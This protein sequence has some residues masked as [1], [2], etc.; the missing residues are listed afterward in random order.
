MPIKQIQFGEGDLAKIF[1]SPDKI[2][3]RR[4]IIGFLRSLLASALTIVVLFL[5]LN[6]P[7]YY[8]RLAYNL[9]GAPSNF[10]ELPATAPAQPEDDAPV[11]SRAPELSIGKIGSRAPILYDIPYD[12]VVST[13][14]Q[15]VVHLEGTAKPG[16]SGN[17]VLFGHSSDVPWAKSSYRTIF[18][19]IDQ[20]AVGDRIEAI[21]NNT[22]FSYRVLDTAIVKPNAI[23][24]L[25]PT[26]QP[27]LTLISC[28][29]VGTTTNR[30][31]V[32]ALLDQPTSASQA[33]EKTASSPPRPAS[34]PVAR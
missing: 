28:Y 34:L 7:A 4:R 22:V 2:S 14:R 19:L 25:D 18:A 16:E 24:V 21:H 33:Q 30:I 3:G 29:P 17:V 9:V 5:G 11:P 1:R 12:L 15:G 31:V 8:Q 27:I 13:L 6:W 32:R 10:T 26:Q 23:S 20:L